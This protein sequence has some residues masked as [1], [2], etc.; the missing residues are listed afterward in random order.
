M[1]H[2]AVRDLI[3][4]E[5]NRAYSAGEYPNKEL[6]DADVEGMEGWFSLMGGR[7]GSYVFAEASILFTGMTP[8]QE[9]GAPVPV[10]IWWEGWR[11]QL[12]SDFPEAIDAPPLAPKNLFVGVGSSPGIRIQNKEASGGYPTTNMDREAV[13]KYI[14]RPK[15]TGR[16]TK[17]VVFPAATRVIAAWI[18]AGMPM[19]GPLYDEMAQ[20]ATL[21][22]RGD[23]EVNYD[24]RLLGSRGPLNKFHESADQLAALNPGRSVII[25]PTN[26]VEAQSMW[27]QPLGDYIAGSGTKSFDWVDPWHS[28]DRLDQLRRG[29]LDQTGNDIVLCGLDSS[30]FDRDVTP[31]MH[32]GE[33]AWYCAMFPKEVTSLV[34]DAQLPIDV[35]DEW[36]QGMLSAVSGGGEIVEKVTGVRSDGVEVTLDV[37]VKSLTYDF[38]EFICKIMTMINDA[39]IA[40]GDYEVDAPGVEY[41][42]A[43]ALPRLKGLSIVSNGGRRSGDA[44]TGLGNS[45]S[46]NVNTRCGAKMS[47]R[48]ELKKLMDRRAAMQGEPP[49]GPFEVEDLFS[50]GDDLALRLRMLSKGQSAKQSAASALCAT[51]FRANASKQKS[52]DTPRQPLISFANVLVTPDYIGKLVSRSA[53]RAQVQESSGLD[54]AT[55][56]VIR[57]EA[58]EL[59]VELGIMTTTTTAISRIAPLAGFPLLDTHPLAD[60]IARLYVHNDRYRLV[61]LDPTSF[62]EDGELTQEGV[63]RL[64]RAKAVEAKAQAKLRARREN[65]SVD[66]DALSEVYSESTIHGLIEIH[67]LEGKYNPVLKMEETSNIQTFKDKVSTR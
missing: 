25:V 57:E 35:S 54:K 65:V 20:P 45:W 66:L 26:L 59:D 50:R 16:P 14:D 37:T 56:D 34:V 48:P 67:A 12:E 29:D 9:T 24:V 1:E 30:G 10:D 43:G 49:G 46:N 6:Y 63:E 58:G 19:S 33:A 36:V 64:A 44:A 55:L 62:T 27:A 28:A 4:R 32:A 41:S 53:K 2:A 47:Q 51:G 11:E 31:Q 42:I 15:F 23:R 18:E 5:M 22:Y 7:C 3:I 61:Y 8:H 60:Y 21:A 52:S 38:H 17:G 13:S 39:P 40:W